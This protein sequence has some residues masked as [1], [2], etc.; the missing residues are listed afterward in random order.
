[1]FNS[2]HGGD[3]TSTDATAYPQENDPQVVK[4]SNTGTALTMSPAMPGPG[5]PVTF[6]ATV[7][8]SGAT[9]NG[10]VTFQDR[11]AAASPEIWYGPQPYSDISDLFTNPDEWTNEQSQVNVLLL[12]LPEVIKN[13]PPYVVNSW[14]TLV[15]DGILSDLTTWGMKLA[16]NTGVIKPGLGLSTAETE[17]EDGVINVQ[18]SGGSVSYIAMDS[19]CFEGI[20]DDPAHPQSTD[21]IATTVSAFMSKIANDYSGSVQVGDTDPYPITPFPSTGQDVPTIEGYVD[22]LIAKGT[23]PAFFH[24]D[25]NWTY[26]V[27]GNIPGPP[28]SQRRAQLNQDLPDL[29]S[30]FASKGIPF[31]I[32]F[33]AT[34]K[35]L[36]THLGDDVH[37]A[38]EA[39]S[40]IQIAKT[41]LTAGGA[42]KLPD[43]LLFTTYIP[44]LA[45]GQPAYDLPHNVPDS[46]P[47]TATWLVNHGTQELLNSFQDTSGDSTVATL[48]SVTGTDTYQA[49][50]AS[51]PSRQGPT[52][53]R[54]PTITPSKAILPI[55]TTQRIRWTR[56]SSPART[57]PRCASARRRMLPRPR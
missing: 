1:M 9:P 28:V 50:S 38:N 22:D 17:A 24:L 11:S 52:R 40:Q 54:P 6:T 33:Q 27:D 41:A 49:T 37:Y 57:A 18:R 13:P 35:L 30:Y 10:M 45:Q 4:P 7:S 31:G 34:D 3:D 8:A 36:T 12:G 46:Q 23:A 51:P 39:R 14:D 55:T 53:S 32:I 48:S 42:L 16:F 21:Q 26:L 20:T 44:R 19:P 15:H 2:S 29:Q 43:Q 56:T 25:I 5:Q 47:D